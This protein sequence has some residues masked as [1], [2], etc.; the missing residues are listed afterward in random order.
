MFSPL[1]T[2]SKESKQVDARG[3]TFNDVQGDQINIVINN[4]TST[5]VEQ[6]DEDITVPVNTSSSRLDLFWNVS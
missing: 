2:I 6:L 5:D 4:R 3:S 1:V